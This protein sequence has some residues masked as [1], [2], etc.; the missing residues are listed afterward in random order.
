MH[1]DIYHGYLYICKHCIYNIY[2]DEYRRSEQHG[3][4]SQG[5][6]TYRISEQHGPNSQGYSTSRISEQ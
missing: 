2:Q 6:G 1:F 5:Y 4:N 3:Q